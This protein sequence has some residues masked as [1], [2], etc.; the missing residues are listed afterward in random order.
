MT[1]ASDVL[2]AWDQ[3][4]RLIKDHGY[5]YREVPFRLSSGPLSHD[6]IDGK[7]AIAAGERL[8]V[9]SKAMIDHATKHDMAFTHVGG[10]TMG[11]DLLAGGITLTAG[12]EW[13]SVRKEPKKHGLQKW[14]EGSE[15][16]PAHRVLLVDDV[17]TTGRSIFKAYEKVREVRAEVIGVI[18]M[19]DRGEEAWQTFA[20]L[21]V[22]YAPLLTYRDLG[23]D[24]VGQG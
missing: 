16:G 6:Y 14:I 2:S 23:I 19:V 21:G 13:F 20:R 18:P 1:Y 10:L 8:R 17:V 4:R 12:A 22:P 3:A 5:E 24:P 15:L 11:A 9:V 7:R